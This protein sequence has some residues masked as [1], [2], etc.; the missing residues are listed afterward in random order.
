MDL[1][2]LATLVT[3]IGTIFLAAATFYYAY[4]NYKL[5]VAQDKQ[6]KRPRKN[7]E[8]H[9][10]ISPLISNYE[11][12]LRNAKDFDYWNNLRFIPFVNDLKKNSYIGFVYQDFISDNPNLEPKINKHDDIL[13]KINERYNDLFDSINTDEFQ[14]EI[15]TRLE[16]FNQGTKKRID[17]SSYKSLAKTMT[18]CIMNNSS[19]EENTVGDP[20]K[21]FWKKTGKELLKIRDK[22]S[23]MIKYNELNKLFDELTRI[24]KTLIDELQTIC[25]RYTRDYGITLESELKNRFEYQ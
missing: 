15:K 6:L 24:N 4:T 19:L 1:L 13:N 16:E 18:Y 14:Q 25:N 10:V 8:I 20:Y 5:M 22:K 11:A 12:E 3:A 7:D 2:I 23:F 21:S 17:L 9:H